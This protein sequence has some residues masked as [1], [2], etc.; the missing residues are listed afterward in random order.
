MKRLPKARILMAIAGLA[1][2]A[3]LP[4]CARVKPWERDAL[5]DYTMRPDRDP[6]GATLREHMWFSREASNGGRSIGG[7]GCGCN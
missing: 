7:G 1:G 2:S 3:L 6:V 5:A 4:G